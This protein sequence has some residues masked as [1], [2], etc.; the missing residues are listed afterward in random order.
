MPEVDE[1]KTDNYRRVGH[2][3]VAMAQK[4]DLRLIVILPESPAAH[5]KR[6]R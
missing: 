5:G 6:N 4:R 1:L 2:N 3:T